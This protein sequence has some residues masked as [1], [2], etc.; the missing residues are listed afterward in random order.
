MK[1]R[2]FRWDFCWKSARLL[3]EINGGTFT[4][5]AHSTGTGLRR[6]Y[7]KNNLAQLAGWRCLMFDGEMVI[8][9]NDLKEIVNEEIIEDLDHHFLNEVE[10][11]DGVEPTCENMAQKIYERLSPILN[12]SG[13]LRLVEIK[14]YET[15]TSYTTYRG[16]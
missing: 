6:D 5:G 10:W 7:E 2:K 4:K 1:G 11:L 9:F 8:D 12:D 3:V 16:N 15:P 14:L 13:H